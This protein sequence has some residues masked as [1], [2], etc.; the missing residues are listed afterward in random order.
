MISQD[1]HRL[2]PE[3][4]MRHHATGNAFGRHQVP[5]FPGRG[6][7]KFQ[8]VPKPEIDRNNQHNR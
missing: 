3:A 2:A 5:G 6:K 1:Q 7:H 8:L 4:L